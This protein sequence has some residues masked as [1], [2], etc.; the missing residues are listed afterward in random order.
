MRA[1]A[2]AT[3]G[4]RVRV[5][6]WGGRRGWRGRQA[7]DPS[8]V[9]R[10]GSLTELRHGPEP[11]RERWGSP[12]GRRPVG[13]AAGTG[14]NAEDRRGTRPDPR[15]GLS[16]DQVAR[17]TPSDLPSPGAAARGRP[18]RDTGLTWQLSAARDWFAGRRLQASRPWSPG[19]G[20]LLGHPSGTGDA[21]PRD[22]GHERHRRQAWRCLRQLRSQ[23]PGE[24][25]QTGSGG[26]EG[27]GATAFGSGAERRGPEP[28]P[29]WLSED[30]PER[31]RRSAGRPRRAR[32]P[33]ARGQ[34]PAWRSFPWG[35]SRAF[36]Q[37]HS[38][39]S[40]QVARKRWRSRDTERPGERTPFAL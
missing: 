15:L 16:Q 24:P 7:P 9:G 34:R 25:G 21:R 18:A 31:V 38:C 33:R 37:R 23:R 26:E 6:L 22:T 28:P 39:A 1:R 13:S 19:R 40:V 32:G 17:Q 30:T 11:S 12:K 20:P 8:R 3:R 5:S 2:C 36:R 35:R 27:A 4:A 29:T 14:A 10:A